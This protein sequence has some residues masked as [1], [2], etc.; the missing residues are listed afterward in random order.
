MI[1]QLVARC[2]AVK[3]LESRADGSACWW[4]KA[5]RCADRFAVGAAQE[6]RTVTDN[7]G[8][9]RTLV[10]APWQGVGGSARAKEAE[11]CA[12]GRARLCGVLGGLRL[13]RRSK[14]GRVGPV[15]RVGLVLVRRNRCW[16][17][18]PGEWRGW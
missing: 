4:G 14:V 12:V 9:L 11:G 3:V 13:A 8:R 17:F 10:G 15:G 1:R 5:L 7:Y 2:A 18:G 16:R 6:K